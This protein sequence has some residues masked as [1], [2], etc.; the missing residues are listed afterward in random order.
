[1]TLTVVSSEQVFI[2]MRPSDL[3]HLNQASP[4][5]ST[6]GTH[7]LTNQLSADSDQVTR[8]LD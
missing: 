8:V 6:R 2:Y 4:N 5:C 1:M 7:G 3:Q